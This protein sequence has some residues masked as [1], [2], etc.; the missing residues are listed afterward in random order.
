MCQ[1]LKARTPY[2]QRIE[3]KQVHTRIRRDTC[4]RGQCSQ[5]HHLAHALI[6]AKAKLLSF[7]SGK[8]LNPSQSSGSFQPQKTNQVNTQNSNQGFTN[9]MVTK[10]N[11]QQVKENAL[12]VNQS[13]EWIQCF[14]CQ[15]W[16]HKKVDCPNKANKKKTFQPPLP[17]QK[18]AFP[19]RPKNQNKGR[20]TDQLRNV[21]IN[22]V[23]IN[24]EQEEQ[25]QVYG[26]QDPSG[27]NQQ[28]TI[29][30]TQ[31]DYEGKSLTFLMI[32]GPPIHSYLW[33]W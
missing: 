18:E 8:R 15:Q 25:A 9:P 14:E 20:I 22:Y 27:S 19:N 1:A 31:G 4:K 29:L 28:F 5:T 32:L 24:D 13:G 10:S 33:P 6:R 2:D 11:V 17:N 26:A 23:N 7:Q 16:G 12:P 21:K 3:T 30:E